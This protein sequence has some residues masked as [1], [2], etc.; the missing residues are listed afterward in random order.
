MID[1]IIYSLRSLSKRKTRSFLTTLS[2]LIG[3]MS[4]FTLLSFGLGIQNY[5]DSIAEESG[6]DKFFIQ[7]AGIGAPGTDTTFQLTK[8]E[9]DYVRKMRDVSDIEGI[10]I[11]T[12]EIGFKKESEIQMVVAFNMR[13]AKFVEQS[14][15]VKID[16][17]RALREDD[18]SKVVLGYSYQFENKIFKRAVEI[19]DKI[20]I[21][22]N[23][24]DVVGFYSEVGNPIDDA[25][26][27]MSSRGFENLF[28]EL[29]DGYSMAIGQAQKNE[30]VKKVA[31]HVEERLRKYKGEEKGKETFFVQ[32]YEDALETFG[33]IINVLNGILI[34]IALISVI[35]A[36][37]NIMNTMYTAVLERTQEIGIMKA[38]GAP[39]RT[40]MFIFVFESAFLGFIGGILGILLG[41][42]IASTGG[43][44][45]AAAGYSL[46]KPIFP[47]YLIIGCLLF[48]TIIGMIAGILPAR[49]ASKQNPVDALKSNE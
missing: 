27:Y 13:N 38:V 25:Y 44:I 6:V 35:V 17:G 47:N 21:K 5:I 4:I 3:V 12:S 30:E 31:E 48:S 46:L 39:N 14:F 42:Y 11:T 43:I 9:L 29:K 24:Y 18:L 45:A 40:I 19:G 26:V 37:V 10:Y 15:T 33:V 8:N 49:N 22:G 41:Y 16:K 32:T 28:P 7:A 20:E 34:L 23:K 2:I 36:S 1:E